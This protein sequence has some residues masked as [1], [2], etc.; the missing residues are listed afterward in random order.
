MH[1]MKHLSILAVSYFFLSQEQESIMAPF[2]VD[3]FAPPSASLHTVVPKGREGMLPS[4]VPP[5]IVHPEKSRKETSLSSILGDAPDLTVGFFTIFAACTP[6]A[7]ATVI[8]DSFLMKRFF[9]LFIITILKVERQRLTG[10]FDTLL[11]V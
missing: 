6:Y 1:F 7:L 10:R 9:C 11:W 4:K 8:E 2:A 3:A 5:G